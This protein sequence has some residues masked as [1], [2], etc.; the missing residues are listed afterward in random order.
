MLEAP[1][2]RCVGILGRPGISRGWSWDA[3]RCRGTTREP[4]VCTDLGTT[5]PLG[6]PEQ[7]GAYCVSFPCC[8][9]SC[10]AVCPYV[11]SP[12]G[13]LGTSCLWHSWNDVPGHTSRPHSA[14]HCGG[15]WAITSPNSQHLLWDMEAVGRLH[16]P[17]RPKG[18]GESPAPAPSQRA[19]RRG[20]IR[21]LGDCCSFG[22]PQ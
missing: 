9:V 4:C 19:G 20:A 21:R 14:S 8:P 22:V 7:A 10:E 11:L 5:G 15:F 17:L 16:R 12:C 18:G 2:N 6:D 3:S 1:E 13:S